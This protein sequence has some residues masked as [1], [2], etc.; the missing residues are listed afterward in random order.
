MAGWVAV[1][2]V[3]GVG[4]VALLIARDGAVAVLV[5][6]TCGVWK[7]VFAGI[8]SSICKGNPFKSVQRLD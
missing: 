5:G 3:A 4:V 2:F 8:F 1:A 7:V 6:E